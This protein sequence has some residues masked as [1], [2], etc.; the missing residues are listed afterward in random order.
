MAF[1][2][3]HLKWHRIAQRGELIWTLRSQ[4]LFALS[5]LLYFLSIGL[6]FWFISPYLAPIPFLLGI[7]F[8]PFFI[9]FSDFLLFPLV[10]FQKKRITRLASSFIRQQQEKGLITLG[11]TG[12]YGKTTMRDVLQSILQKKYSVFSFPGNRNTDIGI[13]QYILAHQKEIASSEILLAEMGA[14]HI[15]EIADLCDIIYP[16]YSITTTIGQAHLDRFGS[17][18]NIAKGKIELAN[19]TKKKAFLNGEDTGIAKYAKKFLQK[20]EQ[21]FLLFPQKEITNFSEKDDFSGIDFE[22]AGKKF[23][24]RL[25]AKYIPEFA[26]LAFALTKEL[27]VSAAQMQQGIV[28]LDF[29]PHR[30]QVIKNETLH[31]TII[32]DSYNGNEAG[33]LEGLRILFR[34]KG[35]KI[36]LTPGIVELG[37]KSKEVHL[38][39]AKKYMEIV[40]VLLLVQNKNTKTIAKELKKNGYKN[41]KM[42]KTAAEAHVDLPRVLKNGDTILFQNDTTDN[43]A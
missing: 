11:I 42:Y 3:S 37:K 36:V 18:E 7:L 31:R 19:N 27:G 28:D 23:S 12:S 9:I 4:L 38:R 1:V 17:Q 10:Q 2:Y 5:F 6:T 43:Y 16:D 39:L 14:Y 26:V 30:L 8:F 41:Y 32:D 22:Y 40:D 25:I 33:F 20:K 13:A 35:R 34:A 24:T 21:S 15:G 29:V